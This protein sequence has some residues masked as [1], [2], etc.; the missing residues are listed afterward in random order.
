MSV[1]AHTNLIALTK[2]S[3]GL[4]FNSLSLWA[5]YSVLVILLTVLTEFL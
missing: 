1:V 4:L 3:L 2:T 5:V